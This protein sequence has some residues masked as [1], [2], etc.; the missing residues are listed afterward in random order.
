MT[1]TA[2]SEFLASLTVPELYVVLGIAE[3]GDDLVVL[4]ELDRRKAVA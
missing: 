1:D 4:A 3:R 2:T